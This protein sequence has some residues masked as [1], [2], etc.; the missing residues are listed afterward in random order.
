MIFMKILEKMKHGLIASFVAL[1]ALQLVR[2]LPGIN[3]QMLFTPITLI[4]TAVFLI[5]FIGIVVLNTKYKTWKPKKAIDYITLLL[6]AF[7]IF[8]LVIKLILYGTPLF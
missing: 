2:V 4:L 8:K 1:Y 3:M 5:F 6:M 7:Y